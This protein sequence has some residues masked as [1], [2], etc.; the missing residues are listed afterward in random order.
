MPDTQ[1]QWLADAEAARAHRLQADSANQTSV[2][3]DKADRVNRRLEELNIIPITLATVW[4]GDGSVTPAELVEADQRE[5]LYSVYAD[6]DDVEGNVRLLL[7]HYWNDYPGLRPGRLLY[8]VDDVVEA[9]REGPTLQQEPQSRPEITRGELRQIAERTAAHGPRGRDGDSGD[10]PQ[11]MAGLAAAVLYLA[12]S[13]LPYLRSPRTGDVAAVLHPSAHRADA[14]VGDENSAARSRYATP[15]HRNDS[16]EQPVV[17]SLLDQLAAHLG[18]PADVTAHIVGDSIYVRHANDPAVL[19]V[20]SQLG[21][22]EAK[23]TLH[24]IHPEQRLI[25]STSF[26]LTRSQDITEALQQLETYQDI[27]FR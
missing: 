26:I 19:K 11:L 15:L 8:T 2:V 17:V 23:L 1:Q 10:L 14:G 12:D 6:W 27:W 4:E 21:L 20:T 25:D 24:F 3:R 18:E 13:R 22:D 16:L 5:E 7:G 9:R